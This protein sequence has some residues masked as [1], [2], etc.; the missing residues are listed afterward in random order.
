VT[1][2]DLD[3]ANPFTVEVCQTPSAREHSMAPGSGV[4]AKETAKIREHERQAEEEYN[5][6]IGT[7]GNSR[8][9]LL[10]EIRGQTS[11]VAPMTSNGT[12]RPAMVPRQLADSAGQMEQQ[13]AEIRAGRQEQ[14]RQRSRAQR[15]AR[16]T[17]LAIPESAQG[18]VSPDDL[19]DLA[20]FLDEKETEKT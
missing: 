6:L 15:F 10:A 17:G 12:R 1:F 14:E 18:K 7:H 8:R 2:M 3:F 4:L 9:Q 16:R 11:P 19:R 13:R 5:R 20:E